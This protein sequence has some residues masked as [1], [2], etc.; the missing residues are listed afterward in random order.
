VEVRLPLLFLIWGVTRSDSLEA[1]NYL[2]KAGAH[3]NAATSQQETALMRAARL[4]HKGMVEVLL[5]AGADIQA[6]NIQG[7]TAL[8]IARNYGY[9]DIVYLLQKTL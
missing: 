1:V 3:V 8:D 2:L 4:G 7:E 9:E 5:A 6:K